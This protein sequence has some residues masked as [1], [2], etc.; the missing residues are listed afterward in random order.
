MERRCGRTR[1]Q[2]ER[3]GLYGRRGAGGGGNSAA[4]WRGRSKRWVFKKPPRN[5]P[6]PAP[7]HPKTRP[8]PPPQAAAL[9]K[10]LCLSQKKTLK[11]LPAG[12]FRGLVRGFSVIQKGFG[13]RG[14]AMAALQEGREARLL[15]LL[16]E[17]GLCALRAK[18]SA[19]QTADVRLVR[20]LQV[21]RG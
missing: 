14:A 2:S 6:S 1:S 16:E 19:V 3:A 15:A 17:W 20:C 5:F 4:G 13:V 21:K 9:W 7:P 10:K 12:S 18:R 11:L 8:R